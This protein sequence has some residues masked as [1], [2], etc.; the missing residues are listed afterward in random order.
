MATTRIEPEPTKKSTTSKRGKIPSP[1]DL[2]DLIALSNFGFIFSGYSHWQL[3]REEIDALADSL[4][5]VLIA[6][7]K[8]A[9]YL[10]VSG[11]LTA[12]GNLGF[13]LF[14]IVMARMR[15]GS[16]PQQDNRNGSSSNEPIIVTEAGSD[17]P[18]SNETG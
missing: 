18:A 13:V 11:K 6:H 8:L 14:N 1:K 2:R 7:P 17:F 3:T 12:W 10:I 9:A 4:H 15:M 5:A 16:I